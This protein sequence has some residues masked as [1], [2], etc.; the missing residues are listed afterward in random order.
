MKNILK[1]AILSMVLINCSN[2]DNNV[3]NNNNNNNDPTTFEPQNIDIEIIGKGGI[4]DYE[5]IMIDEVELFYVIRNESEID[6]IPDI[7]IYPDF[8]IKDY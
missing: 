6:N 4:I 8:Y 7:F 5:S 1:I 3:P 2:N